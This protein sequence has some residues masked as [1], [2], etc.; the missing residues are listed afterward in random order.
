MA[1]NFSK[2][3]IEFVLKEICE[4]K[5]KEIENMQK[6]IENLRSCITSKFSKLNAIMF[7]V[8]GGLIANLILL[9]VMK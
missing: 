9:L 2:K 3:E 7:T 1:D 6:E 5:H 4:I 8:L